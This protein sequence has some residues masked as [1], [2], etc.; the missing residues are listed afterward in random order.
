MSDDDKIDFGALASPRDEGRWEAM[1]QQTTAR[2]LATRVTLVS[3][4]SRFS[5]PLVTAAAAVMVVMALF[6]ARQPAANDGLSADTFSDWA[7]QGEIP[8][9]V[10]VVALT[11]DRG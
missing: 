8:H 11:G 5:W 2:A 3:E 7:N 10:D 1:V 4:L 6:L 9:T